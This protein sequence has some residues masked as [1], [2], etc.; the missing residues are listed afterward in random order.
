MSDV[1]GRNRLDDEESPYLRQHADNPVNWQPWDDD[2]LEVAR[3]EDKPIFLSVGY[4]ACHWCHVMA[5]ESFEDEEV[6]SVL[7]ESFVPIKVD[8]EERPDLDRIY[9]TICQLVT[10]GGGWPLSVWLTPEG[11]PFYVGTYFPKEERAD[12]GNVPG[13]LDLLRS[14]A[15]SWE[16]DREEIENRADQ[17]TD[18][19][20]DNLETTPEASGDAP[21]EEILGTV[22]AAAVRGADREYGGFGSGGPKFPQARR[23]ESLLRTYV[24]T[25]DETAMDVATQTLDAMAGGGLYDHVGG[26][27][28]RYATD[29]EWT[30]PHFE[31]MLYDNA[32]LPRVY[33]AAHRL[34]G[35]ED[36]AQV[37]RGTF[38]FVR[39]E[40]R[41]PDGGFYS[42]LDARSGGEEGTFYVWT[43][44]QVHEALDDETTA[45]LFCDRFGVTESGNFEDGTTVLTVSASFEQ[46]AEE[47]DLS[48]EEVA[49]RLH[50]ARQTLF[51]AREDRVRPA[52]DEKVLAGWNGL[53]ISSL[54]EGGL[55]LGDEYVELAEDAL[56]FVRDH[57]WDPEERRLARRY[58]DGDVKGDGYLEDYAFLARG[59]FDLYQAT[60]DAEYLA[61]AL[62]L[63]RTLEEQFYDESAGTLYMTPAEGESL[64]TRPQ[65]LQDQSTP[66]S[67]GVAASLL[68]DLDAFAP[69]ADF[70]SVAGAVVDTHGDRI[71]GRP[72]E[73]VSLAFAAEKRA[74]GGTE[75]VVAAEALPESWRETLADRY[76]PDTVLSVR[77]PTD[78]EL[79]PWLDS[80][81]LSDAP[82]VWKG[83]EARDGEPTVYACEGR[84][85][86]APA[87]SVEEALSWLEGGADDADVSLDDVD[88]IDL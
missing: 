39:R 56:S 55:V 4:S 76:V 84:T 24:R 52:R 69:E 18:A 22:A 6:A 32:E 61:F 44:E 49:D 85:C 58:K 82:P 43:P 23:V 42:T 33:V 3:E 41:H 45:D 46:L 73:H 12:R 19:L 36:Y 71:R 75:L 10:G 35:R 11:R 47:Y 9:Q 17:W 34:T 14:F 53:M 26:G 31:K 13:F 27:F 86:S 74:L 30:V 57:L 1:L 62:D 83:R 68:L 21:G 16:T 29:R 15:E 66:S 78:D 37:A 5:E 38:E 77:P 54:A 81:G 60:G 50:E 63:T 88:D 8:R 40:L 48:A 70:A 7:N 65:E 64:V 67:V 28:H 2:A 72:L 87:H 79:G 59:A 20:R 51:E 25:G 80:L